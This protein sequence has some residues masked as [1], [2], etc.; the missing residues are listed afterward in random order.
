MTGTWC[1][2]FWRKCIC[3]CRIYWVTTGGNGKKNLNGCFFFV[4]VDSSVFSLTANLHLSLLLEFD[5]S[6][7]VH[8]PHFSSKGFGTWFY[9]LMFVVITSWL[10][11]LITHFLC[12]RFWN[13]LLLVLHWVSLD[14]SKQFARVSTVSCCAPTSWHALLLAV[15]SWMEYLWK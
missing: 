10:S 7:T 6:E 13:L 8:P 3:P 14:I 9:F 11:C 5:G 2:A 1:D 12:V 4:K 15:N